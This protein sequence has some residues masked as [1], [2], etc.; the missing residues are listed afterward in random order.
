MKKEKAIQIAEN[1][2]KQIG[3]KDNVSKVLHCQT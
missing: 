3:G 2:L 1:V